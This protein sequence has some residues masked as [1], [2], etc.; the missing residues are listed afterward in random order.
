MISIIKKIPTVPIMPM[1]L[2]YRLGRILVGMLMSTMIENMLKM[3]KGDV[4]RTL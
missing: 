2:W 4:R 3:L 1:P